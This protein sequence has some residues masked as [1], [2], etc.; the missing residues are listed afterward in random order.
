M[1]TSPGADSLRTNGSRADA[2]AAEAQ[3]AHAPGAASPAQ[4]PREA[5]QAQVVAALAEIL[6]RAAILF[7]HEDTVPYECDALTAYR[8][9]PLVVVIPQTEAQVAAVLRICHKMSVPI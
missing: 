9:S 4:P 6:P 5:R 8:V 7:R 3:R 1:N 2:P